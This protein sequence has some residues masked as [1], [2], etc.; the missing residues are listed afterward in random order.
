MKRKFT[1]ATV[2]IAVNFCELSQQLL[3]KWRPRK[4]GRLDVPRLVRDVRSIGEV[5]YNGQNMGQ[6][7]RAALFFESLNALAL[8]FEYVQQAASFHSP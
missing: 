6:R 2:E 3:P 7:P 4:N 1:R 5:V 8:S